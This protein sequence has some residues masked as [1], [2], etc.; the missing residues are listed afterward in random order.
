DVTWESLVP[1]LAGQ[2]D[3]NAQP[4][5]DSASQRVA[6]RIVQQLEQSRA[7]ATVQPI[8]ADP[9]ALNE[10]KEEQLRGALNEYVLPER[11]FYDEAA[12]AGVQLPEAG[13]RLLENRAAIK[14]VEVERL[15][16]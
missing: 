14:L 16:R 10:E 13:Q 15:N 5:A 4:D 8:L 12:F 3:Q 6:Q 7:W 9:G 11:G 1:V 2:L